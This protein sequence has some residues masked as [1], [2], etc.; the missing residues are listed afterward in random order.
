[1]FTN[2]S[3]DPY[4][5][6]PFW[7]RHAASS[8]ILVSGWHRMGYSYSDKSY[9]SQL[10]VEYIKKLHAIVGNAINHRRKVHRIWKWLNSTSQCCCLCLVSQLFN[11]SSK[12]GSHST[13]LSGELFFFFFNKLMLVVS[14]VFFVN[15]YFFFLLSLF[16]WQASIKYFFKQNLDAIL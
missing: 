1:M 4:F 6:E 14:L 12:S 15:Y 7:M 10:L 2:C 3:G 13:I 11:V 16:A 9:I 5:M 8:A